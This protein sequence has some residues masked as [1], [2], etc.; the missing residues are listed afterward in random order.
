MEVLLQGML[1][2][3]QQS[4]LQTGGTPETQRTLHNSHHRQPQE[5]KTNLYTN[6]PT[7]HLTSKTWI[8]LPTAT[9]KMGTILEQL[10]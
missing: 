1:Q 2:Q 7:A 4:L 6:P 10:W 3:S 9:W 5:S 8:A